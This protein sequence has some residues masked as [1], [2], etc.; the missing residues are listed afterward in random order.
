MKKKEKKTLPQGET[1][2]IA[3]LSYK[4]K[5]NSNK[6]FIYFFIFPHLEE[7]KESN[8]WCF[9][10]MFLPVS[11]EEPSC[12]ACIQQLGVFLGQRDQ[13]KTLL[14]TV[15]ATEKRPVCFVHPWRPWKKVGPM[16]L[17]KVMRSKEL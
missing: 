12:D 5:F 13:V 8:K 14:S 4:I 10:Y 6:I 16:S 15:P 17:K 7:V 2:P 1:L 3:A 9:A 11:E